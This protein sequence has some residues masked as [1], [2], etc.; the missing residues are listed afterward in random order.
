MHH[1]LRFASGQR[2]NIPALFIFQNAAQW[3]PKAD[4]T[5]ADIWNIPEAVKDST[6]ISSL[7]QPV[8]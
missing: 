2:P 4:S 1:L 6:N 3:S 8:Y 5:Q 7:S